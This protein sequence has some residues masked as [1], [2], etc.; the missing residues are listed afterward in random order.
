M[1]S[2]RYSKFLA[3]LVAS[4]ILLSL[5]ISLALAAAGDTTRVSVASDGMQGDDHSWDPSIS[6]D[7]RYV[8]FQS[9]ASNL[10]SG[11]TNGQ[12]DIFVHDRQSWQ[13]TRVSVASDGT[14]GNNGSLL[15]SI[16]ADGRY[17][18]FSSAA[19]NLVSGDTNWS[20]DVF[21]HDR[22]SGQTT[23]V[24]VDSDSTQGNSFSYTQ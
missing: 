16:S 6:A 24:S 20:W 17:V 19:S 5:L 23:R 7:G 12:P 11:D 8:A 22:Q 3:G 14:Q 9:S 4:L 2:R 10:V 15:S 1:N 18:A 21:V 13:T